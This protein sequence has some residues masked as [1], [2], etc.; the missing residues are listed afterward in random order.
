MAELFITLADSE[1]VPWGTYSVQA[2]DCTADP[3][4]EANYSPA[5]S[6]G[7]SKWGDIVGGNNSQP[8]NGVVDFNDISSL[9][10]KFKNSTGA[11][12]KS[13]TDIAPQT[14]DKIIDFQ[15]I[16]AVVDAFK[17]R[18]YPYGGLEACAR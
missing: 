11:P 14:P 17:G 18:P 13:Q 3:A 8:P 6:I 10:D 1:V 4:N 12:L 7:S 2:I 16:P 15:D 9:V 5:L